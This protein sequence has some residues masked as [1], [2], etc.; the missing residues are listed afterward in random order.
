MSLEGFFA[1]V[2][3]TPGSIALHESLYAYSW[4]ESAHVI[5]ITLFVGTI[6]MVD[7]RLLGAAFREVPVSQM[8][9]R[10]LPWT[11]AGFV[12][13]VATGLLLFYAI[14]VRTWHSLWFRAKLVLIAI[15]A[16]NIWVFHRRVE[17]DR[18]RWDTAP[19]PPIGA[20]VT[21]AISLFC[22]LS[23]IVMGRMIAY[24]WFDCDKPQPPLVRALASC[25]A[26][27]F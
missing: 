17:R 6:A 7:L 21:A 18:E 5:G 2:A 14:P 15:A 20:R 1:W 8:N 16:I 24:N 19:K 25:P 23:V 3:E 22:W 10:V 13:M 9:A 4:I 27:V 12:L 11:V 26:L